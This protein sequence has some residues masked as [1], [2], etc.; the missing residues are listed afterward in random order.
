MKVWPLKEK[1]TPLGFSLV[2]FTAEYWNGQ[3]RDIVA[4]IVIT[5]PELALQQVEKTVQ[6]GGTVVLVD[7]E[8][9]TVVG[10]D[11]EQRQRFMYPNFRTEKQDRVAIDSFPW[12]ETR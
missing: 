9:G 3:K 6:K 5:S 7:Q 4:Q 12:E 10:F 11:K 8:T 2:T 1:S